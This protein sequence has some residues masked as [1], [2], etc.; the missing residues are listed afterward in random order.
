M[1]YFFISFV[2]CAD[3]I[4]LGELFVALLQRFKEPAVTQLSSLLIYY[5]QERLQNGYLL[6]IFVICVFKT[7]T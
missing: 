2:T 1:S 7:A 5:H 4:A 6:D 3:Y